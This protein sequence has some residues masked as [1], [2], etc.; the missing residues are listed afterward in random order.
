MKTIADFKR[1]MTVGTV[2]MTTHK[3]LNPESQ[4]KDMGIRTCSVVQSNSFAFRNPVSGENSWC[5]WPKK[6][7]VSFDGDTVVITRENF[8]QLTY[9]K[10]R[11]TTDSVV[12]E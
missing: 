5:D 3:F 7:E 1:E 4:L 6:S 9:Q 12:G 8:C 2:W 10:I 11:Y